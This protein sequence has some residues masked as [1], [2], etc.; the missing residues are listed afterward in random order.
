MKKLDFCIVGPGRLGTAVAIL[1]QKKGWGF[2]GV[3]GRNIHKARRVCQQIGVGKAASDPTEITTQS[4]VVLITTPDDVISKVCSDIAHSRGFKADS[5]VAHFSGVLTSAAL[6]TAGESGADIGSIHPIQ[7]FATTEDALRLIPGSYCCIEGNRRAVEILRA[8]AQA[9]NMHSLEIDASEK[10]LYH[11]GAVF[12]SNFL[13]ALQDIAMEL[14]STCGLTYEEA[15]KAFMPLVW[16]TVKNIEKLGTVKA[17]TGPFARGDV[18]TIRRHI[19][20]IRRRCPSALP[21]YLELG[22]RSLQLSILQG[23]INKKQ[24]EAIQRL[25][26]SS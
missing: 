22:K 6:N 18:E 17:L 4:E 25:L 3:C 24:A 13:V 10:G 14:E 15:S 1:L 12:A 16:G 9:L 26:E 21:A 2:K 19:K 8:M 20:S 11:A 7:S 23:G 5:V